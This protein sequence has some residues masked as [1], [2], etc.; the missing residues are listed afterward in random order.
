MEKGL[1]KIRNLNLHKTHE[2][3]TSKEESVVGME[4]GFMV[5]N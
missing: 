1:T 2:E 4:K 5:E 3:V